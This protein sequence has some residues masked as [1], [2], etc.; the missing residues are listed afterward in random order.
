ME[1]RAQNNQAAAEILSGFV[2]QGIAQVDAQG[3][4]SVSDSVLGSSV[5]NSNH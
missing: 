3:N 5:R 2:D 1:A 4:V